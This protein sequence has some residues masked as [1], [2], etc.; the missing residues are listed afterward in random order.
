M[1]LPQPIPLLPSQSVASYTSTQ[2]ATGIGEVLF[3]AGETDDAGKILQTTPFYSGDGTFGQMFSSQ[4]TTEADGATTYEYPI[5]FN[6][7]SII[8]AGTG[9][10]SIPGA[11]FNSDADGSIVTATLVIKLIHRR[12]VV[13]TNIVNITG[14]AQST[15]TITSVSAITDRDTMF[16]VGFTATRTVLVPSDQLVLSI[17]VTITHTNEGNV[18]DSAVG[19]T[20]YTDSKDTSTIGDL[21]TTTTTINIPFKIK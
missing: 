18:P 14:V 12:G 10:F 4:G 7:S 2:F 16:N 11:F 3:Y 5:T 13:D 8:E 19:L 6:R 9:S 1:A 15:G 20:I 21:P 17:N